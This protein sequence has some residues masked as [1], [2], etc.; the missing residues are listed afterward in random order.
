MEMSADIFM[1]CGERYFHDTF[2]SHSWAE[3]RDSRLHNLFKQMPD[4]YSPGGQ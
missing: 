4:L 2:K 3:Q 1:L